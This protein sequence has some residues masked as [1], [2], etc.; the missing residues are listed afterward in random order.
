MGLWL[1]HRAPQGQL[2]VALRRDSSL[3]MK[4][5]ELLKALGQPPGLTAA[6]W[7]SAASQ[8]ALV[9]RIGITFRD[10]LDGKKVH[11]SSHLGSPIP[12]GQMWQQVSVDVSPGICLPSFF[13]PPSWPPP[14]CSWFHERGA[15]WSLS[16]LGLS[17]C[18]LEES[19]ADINCRHSLC[20]KFFKC[21]FFFYWGIKLT[22]LVHLSWWAQ[23]LF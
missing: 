20:S 14:T 17:S 3:L 5:T 9:A 16:C 1:P 19:E 22:F 8:R 12:E 23:K 15:G 4:A 7:Q 18:H 2:G 11:P 21:T 13:L 10:P 6:Q